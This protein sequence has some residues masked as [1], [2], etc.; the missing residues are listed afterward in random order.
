M[1]ENKNLIKFEVGQKYSYEFFC[2]SQ[3]YTAEVVKR[4]EKS[5][6]ISDFGKVSRFKINKGFS[7]SVKGEQE[8]LLY[9][10]TL[11]CAGDKV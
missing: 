10:T 6:W 4:T 9:K 8:Y 7:S 1:N 11:L 3:K 2:S 5:V